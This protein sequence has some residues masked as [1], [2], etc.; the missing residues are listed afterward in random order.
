VAKSKKIIL[1]IVVVL[2]VAL[3]VCIP[4]FASNSVVSN[5]Y[6]AP[7]CPLLYGSYTTIDGVATRKTGGY[8]TPFRLM[9][10]SRASFYLTTRYF[11]S[12]GTYSILN[13]GYISYGFPSVLD[14]SSIFYGASTLNTG[15]NGTEGF[16]NFV[17]YYADDVYLVMYASFGNK[18]NLN[19]S[20]FLP[21]YQLGGGVYDVLMRVW[22]LGENNEH[23]YYE[24]LIDLSD[25]SLY[26]SGFSSLRTYI[27]NRDSNFTSTSKIYN[28]QLAPAFMESNDFDYSYQNVYF[29]VLFY[30]PF[31]NEYINSGQYRQDILTY[32]YQEGWDDAETISTKGVWGIVSSSVGGFLQFEIWEGFTIGTILLICICVPLFIWVLKMLAGG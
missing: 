24:E 27:S 9:E 17:P 30:I 10:N 3:S 7:Y 26:A 13:D 19:D 16:I 23:L 8:A 15:I 5:V 22:Y 31:A 14:N 28:V 20:T 25:S 21:D 4:V 32:G 2:T 18:N 6:S 11:D 12:P 1:S 29:N